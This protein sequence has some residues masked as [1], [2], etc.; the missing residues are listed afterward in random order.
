MRFHAD[1]SQPFSIHRPLLLLAAAPHLPRSFYRLPFRQA[2]KAMKHIQT[3]I[4]ALV[5]IVLVL[6]PSASHAELTR[7]EITSRVDVLNGKPFGD[8]G[9]YEKIHGKAYFAVDPKNPRNQVIADIDLVPRNQQGHV[10]FSA[11]VFILKPKDSS[12]G[13][14]VVFF[15]VVNRGRFRL[16]STFGGGAAVDDP[17]TDA[18]FGNATL[19]R[20]G[21]TLVAVGWQFDVPDELIGLQAPLPTIDGQPIKGWLREWFVPN[22]PTD[23][24]HWTGGYAT[25]GYLPVDVSAADYRLTSR[26]GMFTARHLIPRAEWRF[27]R[28]VDGRHVPDPNFL[29]LQGGFKPGLTYELAYESQNPPVAGLGLAAVRDMASAMKYQPRIVAPGRLAYMYGSS[30]TGRTLRLII[31]AGFTIDERGR[32]VFDAAFVKTGGASL[33]RFNERFGLVN[34]LGVFTETQFPF[35]YQVTADPVTGK[36]DGLGARIPA[37]LEPKIF[38]FDTGSEYW[39]KGRLGALRHAAIDGTADVADAPNVRVYYVAGSRHGSGTVPASDGG[40]Q[41]SNNTLSYTWAERGLMAALDAWVREGKEPPPS[42][43]PRLDDGTMVHHHQLRFPAIPGVQWPTGVPGGYRWDVETPVSALPFLLSQVDADGNEI[44][45]IRLPE[46]E[47]PLGTLTGWLFRSQRIGAPHTLVINGGAYI[48]FPV[49]RAERE[50][51]GDPRAAIEE[52]Y[53][54]RADYLAKIELV[55]RKLARERYVLDQDVPAI[56]AAAAKHWDWRMPGAKTGASGNTSW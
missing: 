48:P 5:A 4:G 17:T 22:E 2:T 11:D 55:A 50:K 26:E 18:H 54:G 7:L 9:P 53:A 8:A 43:H 34:S 44:G 47:V 35:Q 32:K 28:V 24:Y 38:L 31:H 33:G 56:V 25:K 45:G 10:E 37:G 27:G 40:G 42:R 41:F 3:S 39:D 14:G 16:L 23:S 19:L 29:T 20:Q 49:T 6:T 13:N 36:R 46:Q 21:F 51:A 30:Q 15:D 52:R 12:L 1:S